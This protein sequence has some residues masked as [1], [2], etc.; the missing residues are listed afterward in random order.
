MSTIEIPLIS[1]DLTITDALIKVTKVSKSRNKISIGANQVSRKL[2]TKKS[3][4]VVIDSKAP[5][6]IKELIVLLAKQANTPI[7][8]VDNIQ[9]I[10]GLTKIKLDE[11]KKAPKVVCFSINDYVKESPELKFLIKEIT[12]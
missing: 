2:L 5:E 12:H 8:N 10:C 1:S 9:D 3:K 6:N 4:I 11:T 7:I